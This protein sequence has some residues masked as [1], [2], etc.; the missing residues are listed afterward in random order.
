[1]EE[2]KEQRPEETRRRTENDVYEVSLLDLLVILAQQKKFII[3]VTF[4]FA[5]LSVFY[6]ILATPM[7]K[8]TLQIMPPTSGSGSGAMAM[9]AASGM[10]DLLGVGGLST[11]ADTVVGITKSTSVLDK[12]IDKNGLMT[13]QPE[14][15]RPAALIA[16]TLASVFP[17]DKPKIRERVRDGLNEQIQSDSDKKSSII[18]VSVVDASPDMAVR[19]AQSVFDETQSVMQRVAVTPSG[20][21][22]VFIES[23]LKDA[24]KNLSEAEQKLVKYQAR[25]GIVETGEGTKSPLVDGLAM[26]QAQ[27]AAKEV[28]LKAA[29]KFGTSSNPEVKRLQAEYSA[30]KA[31]FEQNKGKVGTSPLSGFGVKN[32]PEAAAEYTTLMR[33]YKFREALLELLLK[34]YET[35]KMNEANDPVAIQLLSQP[36][37]PELKDSPKRKKVVVLATLLGA[38]L[39]VF[40]AFIRH[41]MELSAVDPEVAP[42]LDYVRQAFC[43]RSRRQK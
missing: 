29:Q 15:W 16:R 3:K 35:A 14:G 18:T 4:V 1:M 19:L 12:V 39:G 43:F 22:R 7:Y 2:F 37:V 25:T 32:L 41:F 11:T 24:Y 10:G 20:Q 8:S 21:Q 38:F 28:Q 36:T 30:I 9:Q 42:K 26:L 33:E 31:Q 5:V 6:A 23:Q 27:M 13:R 40:L 34:Q 17:S